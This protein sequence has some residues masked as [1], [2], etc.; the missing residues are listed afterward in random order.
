MQQ[1]VVPA[2]KRGT[3]ENAVRELG[4]ELGVMVPTMYW[5]AQGIGKGVG[6]WGDKC[7]WVVLLDFS[8]AE[9]KGK[10]SEREYIKRLKDIIERRI[11]AEATLARMDWYAGR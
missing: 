4:E 10:L 11:D 2:C 9:G 5:E 7:G 3:I 8:G 1:V 6:G